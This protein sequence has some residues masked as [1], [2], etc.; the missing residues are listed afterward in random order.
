MVPQ[1]IGLT[2]RGRSLRALRR[3]SRVTE[4]GLKQIGTSRLP[5]IMLVTGGKCPLSALRVPLISPLLRENSSAELRWVRSIPTK[6]PLA[7]VLGPL[8]LPVPHGLKPESIRCSYRCAL[9]RR[10]LI[11]GNVRLLMPFLQVLITE[12]NSPF[13]LLLRPVSL[14]LLRS[15]IS[16]G[17]HSCELVH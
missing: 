3:T 10:P 15:V 2:L 17:A 14:S 5:G 4:L 16:N 6:V 9:F 8:V 7:T 12:L 13:K 1:N 11:I